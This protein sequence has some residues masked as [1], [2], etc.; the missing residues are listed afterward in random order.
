MGRVCLG[1]VIHLSDERLA[2]TR[3]AVFGNISLFKTL[4][5]GAGVSSRNKKFD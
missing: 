4:D 1:S 3:L 2:R 5:L